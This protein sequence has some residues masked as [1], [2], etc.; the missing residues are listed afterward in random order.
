MSKSKSRSRSAKFDMVSPL[1]MKSIFSLRRFALTA[2]LCLLTS[3]SALC[4]DI[5]VTATAVA[6]SEGP[7]CKFVSGKAGATIT[8]GQTVYYDATAGQNSYKLADANLSAAAAK[9]IGIAMNGAASGQKVRVCTYDPSFT[10]G[11]TVVIGDT[12]WL[13]ATAGGITSTASEGV[14]TGNYVAS[15]G[16]AVSTTKIFLNITRAGAVKP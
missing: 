5:T 13:S 6:S 16:V 7:T 15:L 9:V 2:V 4:A 10:I 8:A 1:I 14:A 3:V 12:F 11:A